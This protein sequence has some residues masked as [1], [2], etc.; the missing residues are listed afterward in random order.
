MIAE[1]ALINF[2]RRYEEQTAK[3]VV[4]QI[5]Q[6]VDYLHSRDIIHR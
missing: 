6:A 4:L 5:L 2:I 3:K 1:V